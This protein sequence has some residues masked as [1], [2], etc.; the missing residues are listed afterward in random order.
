M[1]TVVATTFVEVF[2]ISYAEFWRVLDSFPLVVAQFQN[3]KADE[4]YLSMLKY[5]IHY[6]H[7]SFKD[8]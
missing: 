5:N 7:Y 3:L 4:N 6:H 2:Y 8:R 1:R